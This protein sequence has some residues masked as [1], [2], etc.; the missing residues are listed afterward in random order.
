MKTTSIAWRYW[1]T[2][3]G[4]NCMFFCVF[5]YNLLSFTNPMQSES[6]FQHVDPQSPEK[7]HVDPQ[8]PEK[9]LQKFQV[10]CGKMWQDV[11]RRGEV[12]GP[13]VLLQ[14]KR[15]RSWILKM[16]G[17]PGRIG[18]RAASPTNGCRQGPKEKERES[19]LVKMFLFPCESPLDLQRFM[20]T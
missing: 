18:I 14:Q 19:V 3:F 11:V 5:A 12:I 20:K 16:F 4:R 17:W 1:N 15:C 2:F 7:Q 10:R 9:A 8:L 13:I 6:H